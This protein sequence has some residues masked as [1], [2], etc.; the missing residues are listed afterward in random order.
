M[1]LI[2]DHNFYPTPQHLIE[3]MFIG[4][5]KDK[6]NSVLEPSA[7]KGNIVDYLKNDFL[8]YQHRNDIDCIE[9]EP[10]LRDIL[11]GKDYRVVHDDFLTYRT[12]KQYDIVI[13][14]PPFDQGDRHLLKALQMQEN[15]GAVIC[16][17][18]AET[19]KNPYSNTR[20]ELVSELKRL[21]AEI[22]YIKNGFKDAERKTN[23]EVALIRVAIPE[24][25][26]DSDIFENMQKAMEFDEV[27]VS[28]QQEYALISADFTE[29]LKQLIHQYH[30]EVSA[31][32][33][34]I[35][36]YY[37]MSPYILNS[38]ILPEEKERDYRSPIL[39]LK[40]R[41]GHNYDLINDFVKSVRGKYWTYLFKNKSFMGKLTTNLQ[42]YYYNRIAEMSEYEFSIYNILTIKEDIERSICKGVEETILE[43]F[44]EFS[45]KHHWNDERSDNVHYYNGWKTNKAHKINSKI[46]IPFYAFSSYGTGMET[47]RA[48]QKM[49]DMTKVF[50]YL[51]MGQTTYHYDVGNVIDNHFRMLITKNIPLKYFDV[52]FFKKGTCHIKFKNAEL[53]EKFNLYGSQKKGWLPPSY[54]RKSYGDMTAEEQEVVK[55]FSGSVENY[56]HILMNQD[57][58][59]VNE[60]KLL[61]E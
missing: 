28:E 3:K 9:I 12:Q 61:I 11:K 57:Y 2:D 37:A 13:M 29:F 35:R 32:I 1:K 36:E 41:D 51:D 21:N 5:N 58:Y 27:E 23:V 53:L 25:T 60:Q 47:Y 24:K 15:G 16:L 40:V 30:I 46:I 50:D 14:N 49:H 43:L 38:M 34:L 19:L 20:K 42:N 6:I 59:L 22:E 18:N 10:T 31:G 4:C 7:G 52:T 33:K 48:I 39:E 26:F 17:L 54:G 45:R 55:E 8:R 56:N 44:D